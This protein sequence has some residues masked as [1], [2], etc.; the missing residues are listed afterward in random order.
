MLGWVCDKRSPC[1]RGTYCPGVQLRPQITGPR[2]V[3][4]SSASPGR[5][6]AVASQGWTKTF[7]FTD[8]MPRGRWLTH[9]D[10]TWSA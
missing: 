2:A 3:V 4:Y 7:H 5:W 6:L 9:I 1:V 10:M 8:R